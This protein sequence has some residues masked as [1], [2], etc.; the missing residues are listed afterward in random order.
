[1]AWAIWLAVPVG[2]TALVAVWSWVRGW[3]ARRAVRPL[4]TEQA[5][6]LH[7]DYLDA[8]TIPAR[9]STRPE[10]RTPEEH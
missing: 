2:A 3:W 5:M 4:T 1:M 9:S 8:L 7:A 6:Q 10:P